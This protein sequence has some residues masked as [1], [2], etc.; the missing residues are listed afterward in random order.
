MSARNKPTT[1]GQW[2]WDAALF[3]LILAVVAILAQS[4]GEYLC[5]QQYTQLIS[6]VRR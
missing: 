1:L 3:L 2:L 4:R 6:E 5:S